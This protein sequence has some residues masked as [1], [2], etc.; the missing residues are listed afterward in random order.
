MV[1]Y[2]DGHG[3]LHRWIWWTTQIDMLDYTDEDGGLQRWM[4][5]SVVHHIQLC[6]PTCLSV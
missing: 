6:S 5:I 2:T 4:S 1:D 3:G